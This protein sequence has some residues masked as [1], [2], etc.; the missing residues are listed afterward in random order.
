M[1]IKVDKN[2]YNQVVRQ[3]TPNWANGLNKVG[4]ISLVCILFSLPLY[5]FDTEQS[6]KIKN[7]IQNNVEGGEK[8]I[9]D[10]IEDEL[11]S[12]PQG[13]FIFSLLKNIGLIGKNNNNNIKLILEVLIYIQN[14]LYIGV[15]FKTPNDISSLD[16]YANP[17]NNINLSLV[18]Y[19]KILIG[20]NL[21]KNFIIQGLGIDSLFF[22]LGNGDK[23]NY[24]TSINI[25]NLVIIVYYL[26]NNLIKDY[27]DFY[28]KLE[29]KTNDLGDVVDVVSDQTNNPDVSKSL[30]KYLRNASI[31]SVPASAGLYFNILEII[32][33]TK[34]ISI[35]TTKKNNPVLKPNIE[36]T[37]LNL[38]NDS[39]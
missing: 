3:N 39:D 15:F 7:N 25:W 5:I 4:I 28:S 16:L 38:F 33:N 29:N 32:E 26:E 13:I 10:N 21:F 6:T 11:I 35:E 37:P 14:I 22:G 18:D 9:T 36:E 24:L 31:I 27:N 12:N 20:M 23:Q 17:F 2:N 34:N 8:D 19:G 30:I 1:S